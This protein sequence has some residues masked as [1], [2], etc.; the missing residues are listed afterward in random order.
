MY[1]RLAEESN[2]TF[3]SPYS[4]YTA[5]SMTY[6]GARG[7][8]AEGM[9]DALRLPEENG[10]RRPAFADFHK[11]LN[12]DRTVELNTANALW[13]QENFPFREEY[14]ETVGR[15]YLADIEAL[16]YAN[17]SDAAVERINSWAS[18]HTEDRIKK[19]INTLPP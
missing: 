13:P 15:Y 14:L 12:T 1:S 19:I 3:L 11:E 18:E 6:E 16:D 5:L 7:K 8:T 2:N 10:V 9:R 4:I 17:N